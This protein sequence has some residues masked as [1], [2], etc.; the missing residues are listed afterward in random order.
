[1]KKKRGAQPQN[2]NAFKHG[3]YSAAFRSRETSLLDQV[4]LVDLLAEI[5]LLRVMKSRFLESV[6]ASPG[7]LDPAA[8]L[9]ALRVVSLSDQALACLL[10]L[11]SRRSPKD[12]EAEEVL[13]Q[14]MALSDED[15]DDYD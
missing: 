6:A 4:P 1:M 8:Q 9:A 5:D 10:R 11:Q 14:L 2:K 15:I 7:K 13:Q 12:K 3:L